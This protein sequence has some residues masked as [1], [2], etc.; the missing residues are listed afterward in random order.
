MTDYTSK[1]KTRSSFHEHFINVTS[2]ICEEDLGKYLSLHLHLIVH[3]GYKCANNHVEMIF[4]SVLT[5][6]DCRVANLA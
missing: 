4:Q 3:K 5:V 2:N 1:R 6:S